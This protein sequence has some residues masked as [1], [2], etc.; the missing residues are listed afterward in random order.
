MF[1]I[2]SA[3]AGSGKTY[4][5]VKN[6]L[7]IILGSNAYL[8]QRHLLAI[9]FTNKA[10]EE[11]KAR[12]LGALMRFSTPKI[13]NSHDSLFIELTQ[14][15][16]LSPQQLHL[17]ASKL[18]QKILHNYSSFE[19]STIDKFNQKLIRTF[20]HDLEMP[21]NFEVEL[22]TDFLLQQA[23]D[24]L[25]SKAGEDS[26]LTRVLVDYA[27]SKSDD[28]KSW[29]IAIDLNKAAK[30]LTKETALPFLETLRDK[31]LDAFARFASFPEHLQFLPL[32]ILFDLMSAFPRVAH[33]WL[34]LSLKAAGADF[35]LINFINAIYSKVRVFVNDGTD[36]ALA[37]FAK[38]GVLQGCPLSASLFVIAINPFLVNFEKN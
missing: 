4:I 35:K 8:P 14:D 36:Y 20:A 3:S 5:L 38:S 10:V 17:K 34:F 31:D 24:S 16:A 18:I 27:V 7:K 11:M 19:V 23:V 26:A 33:H 29:D 37:F 28:D 22:D 12:I 25:I 21:M 15:L 9:T 6:Y 1:K 2:F 13:L 30:L 32:I